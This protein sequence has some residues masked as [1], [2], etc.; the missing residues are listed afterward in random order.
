MNSFEDKLF[1]IKIEL[2]HI[3]Q[4]VKNNII[5]CDNL[6][7][8]IEKIYPSSEHNDKVLLK[9]ITSTYSYKSYKSS[10]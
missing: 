9:S 7:H 1:F 8:S 5:K 3:E 4:K 2:Y 10:K 6:L